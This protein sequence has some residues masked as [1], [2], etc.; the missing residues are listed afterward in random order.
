MQSL[1]TLACSPDRPFL[2]WKDAKRQ[3]RTVCRLAKI[4]PVGFFR[5]RRLNSGELM[6]TVE[7]GSVSARRR[8][9]KS[10]GRIARAAWGGAEIVFTPFADVSVDDLSSDELAAIIA[11]G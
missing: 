7:G 3:I 8:T 10:A 5:A 6:L 9:V 11:M 1:G 2:T 4:K